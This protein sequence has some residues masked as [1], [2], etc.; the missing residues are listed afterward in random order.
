MKERVRFSPEPPIIISC[1]PITGGRYGSVSNGVSIAKPFLWQS[2]YRAPGVPVHIWPITISSSI[3]SESCCWNGFKCNPKYILAHFLRLSLITHLCT[4][5]GCINCSSE[6]RLWMELIIE[7]KMY[8]I[9]ILPN[10]PLIDTS[11]SFHDIF[12]VYSRII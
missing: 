9:M 2:L 7:F 8:S 3:C 5:S 6:N 1:L 11:D 4:I 10:D 12:F